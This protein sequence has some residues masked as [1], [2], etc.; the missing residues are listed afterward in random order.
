MTQLHSDAQ[1]YSHQLLY[2]ADQ[3]AEHY[4]RPVSRQELLLAALQGLYEA[5]RVP[6][7]GNLSPDLERAARAANADQ[8]LLT[9]MSRWRESLGDPEPL[10]GNHA[11]LA[12]CRAMMRML[13]PYSG[14]ITGEDLRRGNGVDQQDGVGVELAD[15]A[16]VGPL[17]IKTVLP[18]G[19]AQVAGVRPGDEITHVDGKEVKGRSSGEI[20]LLLNRGAPSPTEA[21]SSSVRMTLLRLGKSAPQ[22]LALER[23]DFWPETVLG[24]IRLEDNSW[25]YW[26]DR[27]HRI[28]QVR[29]AQIAK[30]TPL[31]VRQV[32]GRL[33]AHGLRGLILD[34]R[35]CPGG[36][37][38]EAVNVAALFLGECTVAT[39]TSRES[40]HNTTYP[41][42][43]ENKFLEF[44]LVV[45]VNH[46]T[47][48]GAELIAA[49]LQDHHRAR[50]A[51]QRTFGK[52]SIQTTL[53][54]AVPNTGLKLT[55]GMFLRPS[56]KNLHRSPESKPTDDWGVRPDADL[57]CRISP[58]LN[59]QLRDWWQQ[60]TLRPGTSNEALPLD[61]PSADLQRLAVLDV[62]R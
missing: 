32:V 33:Q 38:R 36:Y 20:L 50:V 5:A 39:V 4:I 52:A 31:E 28:A 53:G 16:G 62:L 15:N 48:G 6:V 17:L 21:P 30:G 57:E 26:L 27:E 13:D 8:E 24:V 54:M 3:V 19:P 23:R 58:E 14:I 41:S 11:L 46:E 18:G 34:L 22:T 35:W 51:G 43:A 40:E 2:L 59:R 56:G 61:D 29:I 45:L 55:N 25:D 37:L 44:P 12:S 49:A 10:R 1:N 60:Q 47:S 9:L 7:P 42:T